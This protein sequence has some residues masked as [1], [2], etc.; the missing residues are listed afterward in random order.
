MLGHSSHHGSREMEGSHKQPIRILTAVAAFDGNDASILAFNRALLETDY[1]VEVIYQGFN[2]TAEQIATS[3]IQEG[4]HAVGVG[5]YNGGHLEFYP[6]LVKRLGELGG[7][8]I[9]VF[10]GDV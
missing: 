2:M 5:S 1:P 7:T 9:V 6:H 3:A 10:G 8:R 4:V